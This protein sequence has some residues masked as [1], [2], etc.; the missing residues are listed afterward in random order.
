MTALILRAAIITLLIIAAFGVRWAYA[1]F[2]VLSLTSFF[3]KAGFQVVSPSCELLV[4]PDLALYS[5]RNYPHIVLFAVFFLLSRMQFKG[6]HAYSLAMV[7]TLVMGMLVELAEGF[8]GQ[9]HCRLRDML[10]NTA[11]AIIGALV[12][13]GGKRGWQQLFVRSHGN[14]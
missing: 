14:G 7:A 12:F 10:P 4:G 3:A 2:V 1:G 13:A 9:G 11:G 6:P 5:F 8:S